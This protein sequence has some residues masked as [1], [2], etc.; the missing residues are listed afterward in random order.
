MLLSA[1]ILVSPSGLNAHFVIPKL[2]EDF[3]QPCAATG[4]YFGVKA[5]QR[6]LR[7]EVGAQQRSL[8]ANQ[9][10]LNAHKTVSQLAADFAEPRKQAMD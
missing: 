1:D 7:S 9:S 5:H 2:V 3:A 4:L 6:L 10:G 8:L